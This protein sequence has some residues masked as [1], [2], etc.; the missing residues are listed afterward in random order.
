MPKCQSFPTKT[1]QILVKPPLKRHLA[2][3]SKFILLF[4]LYEVDPFVWQLE[5]SVHILGALNSDK[6]T[7]MCT[8]FFFVLNNCLRRHT[9]I[10][11]CRWTFRRYCS[12]NVLKVFSWKWS[13]SWHECFNPGDP[14]LESCLF[15][16][17]KW[18]W[19]LLFLWQAFFF[20]EL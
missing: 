8:E 10:A 14:S 6:D 11:P 18:L 12:P 2:V 4:Q 9:G 13:R 20:E 16:K 19:F 15:L 7:C 1:K 3:L 17:R 5:F